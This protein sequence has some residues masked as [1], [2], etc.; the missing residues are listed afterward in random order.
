MTV[1]EYSITSWH[2]EHEISALSLIL[3]LTPFIFVIDNR[4]SCWL[5]SCYTVN[6]NDEYIILNFGKYKGTVKKP[7]AIKIK[8]KQ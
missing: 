4:F 5:F 8:N 6:E 2:E 3:R 1:I 7:S